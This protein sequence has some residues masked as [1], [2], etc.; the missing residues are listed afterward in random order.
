MS[1][2]GAIGGRLPLVQS[3]NIKTAFTVLRGPEQDIEDIKYG[4]K[5]ERNSLSITPEMRSMLDLESIMAATDDFTEKN[6]LGQGGFGPVY[7][8]VGENAK[9]NWARK[10][11]AKVTGEKIYATVREEDKECLTGNELTRKELFHV[12]FLKDTGLRKISKLQMQLM[13]RD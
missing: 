13:K 8:R 1:K 6:Q 12:C 10:K 2:V 11:M 7:K 9:A 5:A 4:L 3:N